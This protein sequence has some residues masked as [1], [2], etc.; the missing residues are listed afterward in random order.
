MGSH[1]MTWQD[2]R[3]VPVV[4]REVHL[5]IKLVSPGACEEEALEVDNQHLRHGPQVQL[6]VGLHVALALAAEPA[7]LCLQLLSSLESLHNHRTKV[8]DSHNG[9]F[10]VIYNHMG[11]V[12]VCLW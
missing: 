8:V 6:L 12:T 3:Q 2:V 1:L 11:W 5:H 4:Q 10:V 9:Y 7:I